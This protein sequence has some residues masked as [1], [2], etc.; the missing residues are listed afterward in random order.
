[1]QIDKARKP[2]RG[3]PKRYLL[4]SWLMVMSAVAFLDRTNISIAG[5]QIGR[6]FKIDNAHLGWVFSAFLLGYAA[7][8]IPGGVLARRL[9]PRRV[10]AL[11]VIWSGLFTALTGFVPSGMRGALW[12]LILIRFS[13][14]AGEA[15][16]YPGANQF[17]ERWFP[18]DERGKANGIIFGGVGLGSGLTPLLVTGIIL[19]FG[20]RASFWFSSAAVLIAGT[21]WYLA[22]R[23]TPE[24]HPWVQAGELEIIVRGRDEVC[25]PS[26]EAG[27]KN[28][29]RLAGKQ[30]VPWKKILCSKEILALTFSYFTYGY[31]AWLFF[32]WF[33]IY[34]VQVRGI[35]LKTS[36]FYSMFPFI[37]MTLGSLFGGVASDW[38]V[39]HFGPR[40][41]RC[42]L[43]AFS[44]ACTAVLLVD[45]S[46]AHQAQAASIILACGAGVMY[47]A[48]SC[49]W[50]VT[51]DFAGEYAGIVSGAM[52]TGAQVGGAVTASLTPWIA[53]HF[54]WGASFLAATIFV[55]LGA[56]AWLTIDPC[57]RLSSTA[58][59]SDP[60]TE[61]EALII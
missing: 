11:G 32:S 56:V 61:T 24:A 44:L 19:H 15:L 14:A 30:A 1:M 34:L 40:I 51:A 59:N 38:L 22:A 2:G 49:F 25:G 46:R 23:D 31:V 50:S 48:Q 12:V 7:F 36:A 13:L 42:F 6:E 53:L 43:P 41:G 58:P 10:I 60:F 57:A 39:R 28:S 33:Y 52:N 17:V 29:A 18:I 20:W 5:V 8:Q 26:S 3:L 45:G 47:I 54:G 55:A 4:V 21:I 37:A 16:M 27:E 35:N 9:G